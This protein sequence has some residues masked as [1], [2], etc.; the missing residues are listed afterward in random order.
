MNPAAVIHDQLYKTGAASRRLANAVFLEAMLVL[1]VAAW[2]AYLAYAAV[3]A[4]GWKFYRAASV[5]KM[6]QYP[7]G[8]V[9]GNSAVEWRTFAS[10]EL[11]MLLD[12]GCI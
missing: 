7:A 4:C 12:R 6:K 8:E 2:G 5:S 10:S 11:N 1:D 3:R 9:D